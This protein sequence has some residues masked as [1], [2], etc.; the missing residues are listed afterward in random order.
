[1]NCKNLNTLC[2]LAIYSV[3]SYLLTVSVSVLA[4]CPEQV[5]ASSRL[6]QPLKAVNRE[7]MVCCP[8]IGLLLQRTELIVHFPTG[9]VLQQHRASQWM[10]A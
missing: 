2:S 4:A 6:Q 9:A 8:V 7:L 1:M 10:L 3:W 5:P